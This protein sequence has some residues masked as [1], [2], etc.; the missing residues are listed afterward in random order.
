MQMRDGEAV[1]TNVCQFILGYDLAVC[2]LTEQAGVLA[3]RVEL[4]VVAKVGVIAITLRRIAG[5]AKRLKVDDVVRAAMVAWHDVIDFQRT[6]VGGNATK[7]TAK[8]R[9]LQ[10]FVS[11][12]S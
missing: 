6:F 7:L 8:A 4:P 1:A 5:V 2:R 11:E 12:A 3:L 10:D 9:P